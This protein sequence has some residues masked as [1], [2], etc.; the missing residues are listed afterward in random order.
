MWDGPN[1]Q[2]GTAPNKVETLIGRP[3]AY[4]IKAHEPVFITQGR[5]DM[6][7]PFLPLSIMFTQCLPTTA[8]RLQDTK[9]EVNRIK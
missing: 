7:K 5:I 4:F 9:Q 3:S 2:S 6:C 1:P 8:I